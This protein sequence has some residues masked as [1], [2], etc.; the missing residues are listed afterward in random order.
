MFRK[1]PKYISA[2]DNHLEAWT[3][4]EAWCS[5]WSYIKYCHLF[6]RSHYLRVYSISWEKHAAYA[7]Q[8]VHE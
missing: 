1:T 6:R 3:Q 8:Y 7:E 5:E 4:V 2:I